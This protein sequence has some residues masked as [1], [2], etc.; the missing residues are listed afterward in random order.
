MR[1][2]S[3]FD[4]R[5]SD[6]IVVHHTTCPAAH[7]EDHAHWK[8]YPPRCPVTSTTSP[9][10]YKP[11]NLPRLHGFRR[12]LIGMHASG[13]D[14]RLRV[15][16]R[17][18]RRNDPVLLAFDGVQLEPALREALREEICQRVLQRPRCL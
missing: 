18:G 16:F 10:K 3:E 11:G 15:A 8:L 14:F 12:K 13:R 6:I 4:V 2:E 9:M 1:N 5:S 7:P 17:A